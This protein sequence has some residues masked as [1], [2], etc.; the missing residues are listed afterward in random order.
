VVDSVT[1]FASRAEVSGRAVRETAAKLA[2]RQ[3]AGVWLVG[4]PVVYLAMR[5]FGH[6]DLVS[7]LIFLAA[8][9][10]EMYGIYMLYLLNGLH[11]YRW[12]SV[13]QL[14]PF[15][16]TAIGYVVLFIA[17]DLTVRTAVIVNAASWTL[18]AVTAAVVARMS[19]PRADPGPRPGLSR[20][21]LAFGMKSW[22]SNV[23]HQLND[24]LDQ[25]VISLV[26]VPRQLGLYAIAATIST[27]TSFVGVAVANSVLPTVASL[28]SGDEQV[29]ATRRSIL[30]TFGLTAAA[31][32]TVAAIMHPL[33]RI[34]FGSAFLGAVP[35]ARVLSLAVV[36]QA[37]TRV[38]HGV[39]KGLGRPT[40]AAISEL[41]ALVV[42]GAGLAALVPLIGIMGGALTSLAAYTTSTLI[43][44]RYASRRLGTR[45]IALIWARAAPAQAL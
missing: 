8:M 10:A 36:M 21:F 39:L 3:T 11:R 1:Y 45:P 22:T 20:A 37:E 40:D 23:P 29:R 44:V 26:L 6:S 38:F 17:G 24:Q 15:V 9:P 16:T 27:A 34:V 41:G 42:T 13:I 4:L 18:F 31:G 5:H 32:L 14:L 28:R 30:L 19:T 33:I 43:A 25:L 12:Y 2:V 7:A 35:A